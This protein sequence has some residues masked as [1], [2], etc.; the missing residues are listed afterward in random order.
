MKQLSVCCHTDPDGKPAAWQLAIDGASR[1]N[2]GDSGVG[3][4]I[5]HDGKPVAGHGYFIGTYTNNQAEYLA[6]IIGIIRL[7]EHV[8]EDDRVDIISDSQ[9]L[10]RQMTGEYRVKNP[11]LKK[12]RTIAFELLGTLRYRLCH[13]MRENNKDADAW[14]NKG[15]D[16]RIKVPQDVARLL[17]S[18]HAL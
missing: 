13:V 3:I 14:A 5:T 16:E 2:P 9:L 1:N 15:I 10:V 17:Q 11:E 12:L 7:R 4:V 6:M 18:Y 8:A